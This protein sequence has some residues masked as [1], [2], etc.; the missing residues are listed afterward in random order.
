VPLFYTE[1]NMLDPDSDTEQQLPGKVQVGSATS[2]NEHEGSPDDKAAAK[3][4]LREFLVSIHVKKD[5]L[6]KLV[7]ALMEYGFHAP[8]DFFEMYRDNT[9]D[10]DLSAVIGF[11]PTELSHLTNYLAK[12]RTKAQ[13]KAQDSNMSSSK[14]QVGSDE[15]ISTCGQ[16]NSARSDNTSERAPVMSRRHSDQTLDTGSLYH[17]VTLTA[18]AEMIS[19][20]NCG[21]HHST[22]L[23]NPSRS[24]L[25]AVRGGLCAPTVSMSPVVPTLTSPAIPKLIV[26]WSRCNRSARSSQPSTQA[27]NVTGAEC[28][29][30]VAHGTR[31]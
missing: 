15:H 7:T 25:Q 4:R 6:N 5:R 3:E 12:A 22:P 18:T 31:V 19:S 26:A 16:V 20:A 24:S 13:S 14:V 21:Q 23:C 10:P 27:C 11:T 2:C 9:P 17:W 29:Q 1:F 8:E 30:S 28:A